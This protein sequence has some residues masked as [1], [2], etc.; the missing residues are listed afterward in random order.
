VRKIIPRYSRG[1]QHPV[2]FVIHISHVSASDSSLSYSH[3][4]HTTG[5][6]VFEKRRKIRGKTAK[7]L[8]KDP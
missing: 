3:S 5:V 4:T 7:I 8:E 2:Y 6:F 1:A